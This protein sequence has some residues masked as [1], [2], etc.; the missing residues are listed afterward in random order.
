[1]DVESG[2]GWVEYR[3][4]VTESLGGTQKRLDKIEGRLQNIEKDIAI[5]RTKMYIAS[6]TAAVI[7]SS[8]TTTTIL[9]LT[10]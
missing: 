7:F 3:K 8:I 4:F 6:A 2:N 5:L 10:K 1:M 9:V